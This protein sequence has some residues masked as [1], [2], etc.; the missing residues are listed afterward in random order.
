MDSAASAVRTI[1]GAVDLTFDAG[2]LGTVLAHAHVRAPL[3]V[4]RPFTLED[5]RVL[6]QIL[7]L[8]PGLCAGDQY[9]IA[10]R[11][12]RGARAVVIMQSASRVLGMPPGAHALQHVELHVDA[13]GHLEYYPGLTIP[14]LESSFVQRIDIV[15]AP[16]SR[17]G[18]L[19]TWN[20]G[21][22]MRGEHLAFRRVSSRTTISI[23]G[24]IA[25][26][27][28][29]ELDPTIADI[30][31]TGVLEG[32]SYAASGFWLN[33]TLKPRASIACS[34]GVLC[35]FGESTPDSVYLRA[36]AADGRAMHMTT[37]K[38]VEIV[39]SA[40]GLPPIPLRRFTS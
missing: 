19:E 4:V 22:S 25:Y 21:R 23:H 8:G 36:L 5:G 7:H 37:T 35:A 34:P 15:A 33:A 29:I 14:F 1:V 28:A 26:A 12:R 30:G 13:G 3:K 24:E 6:V 10:V 31:G 18:I 27:D 39:N 40:W 20:T 9:R 11:V 17:V 16:D 32:Y 2:R 38:A